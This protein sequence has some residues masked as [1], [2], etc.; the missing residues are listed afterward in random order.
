[1]LSCVDLFVRCCCGC[2]VCVCVCMPLIKCLFDDRKEEEED[3]LLVLVAVKAAQHEISI[4]KKEERAMM[5]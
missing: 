2:C 4:R 1:M 5:D 3:V